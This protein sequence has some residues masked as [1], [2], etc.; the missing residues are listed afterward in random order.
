MGLLAGDVVIIFPKALIEAE[1]AIEHKRGHECRRVVALPLQN[2]G[3]CRNGFV[4]A[5]S[6][7]RA[8]PV[9]GRIQASK[10]TRVSRQG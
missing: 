3:Q 8:D 2:F 7:V 9:F 4:E 5:S 6:S 1:F 10:Q